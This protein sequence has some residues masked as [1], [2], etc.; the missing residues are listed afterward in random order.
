MKRDDLSLENGGNRYDS[1]RISGARHDADWIS[2]E[3]VMTQVRAVI[4]LNGRLWGWIFKNYLVRNIEDMDVPS[5]EKM[6]WF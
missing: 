3:G 5:R 4:S 6:A 1:D 2:R